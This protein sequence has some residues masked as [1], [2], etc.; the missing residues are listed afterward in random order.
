MATGNRKKVKLRC[1]C[2][3]AVMNVVRD[4]IATG[5]GWV[6]LP[7]PAFLLI[8]AIKPPKTALTGSSVLHILRL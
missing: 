4:W 5:K 2:M 7:D 3:L 1:A 6:S 8:A